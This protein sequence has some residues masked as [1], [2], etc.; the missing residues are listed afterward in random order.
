MVCKR[1]IIRGRVQGVYFRASTKDKADELGIT[2]EVRNL[3][4]G[5]V[6]VLA[7]GAESQLAKLIAWCHEGPT[8]ARV[9]QVLVEELA[10]RRFEGFKV[11][12]GGG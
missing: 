9:E 2:G 6:E 12:R 3:P 5:G 7:C 10:E 8:R 1:I 11:V 4:D